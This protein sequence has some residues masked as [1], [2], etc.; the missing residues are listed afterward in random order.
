MLCKPLQHNLHTHKN[1]CTDILTEQN[2]QPIKNK[3][4][5]HPTK[6]KSHRKATI[7]IF[8]LKY[9]G[10]FKVQA[11]HYFWTD[12]LIKKTRYKSQYWNQPPL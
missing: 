2:S 10:H 1:I 8:S 5:M 3:L 11:T 9:A 6:T 12:H 7:S 4:N